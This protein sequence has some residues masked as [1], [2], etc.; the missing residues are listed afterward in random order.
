MPFFGTYNKNTHSFAE[1]LNKM[2]AFGFIPYDII[3]LQRI[4]SNLLI[5]V[6]MLFVKKKSKYISLGQENIYNLGI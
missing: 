3:T 4:S 1:H 5:Q 2:D 6:D